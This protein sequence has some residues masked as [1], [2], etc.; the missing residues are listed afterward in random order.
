MMTSWSSIYLFGQDWL[1]RHFPESTL[2]IPQYL[3]NSILVML[4]LSGAALTQAVVNV[5]IWR[6]VFSKSMRG[7]VPKLLVDLCRIFIYLCAITG[8]AGTVFRYSLTGFWTTSSVFGLILGFALRNM[9]LDLFSGLAVNIERPYQVGDWVEVQQ[10]S[11]DLNLIGEVIEINWRSTRIRTESNSIVIIPNSILTT[12]VVTNHWGGGYPTRYEVRFCLD[13]SVSADRA[14]R[15][16]LAGVKSVY[17]LIGFVDDH[18]PSIMTGDTNEKGVNYIVRYWI[19]PWVHMTPAEAKNLVSNSVLQHLTKAGLTLAYPKQDLYYAEM[20]I[21]HLDT[22]SMSDRKKI[23][24]NIVLFMELEDQELT[25][26]S[27]RMKRVYFPQGDTV[28]ETGADADSMFILVEGFLQVFS[29][30]ENSQGKMRLGQIIPGEFFGEMSMLTGEPRS[31]SIKAATDVV[32][33]EITKEDVRWLFE[34][35][36]D[37]VE[38]IS[39]TVARRKLKNEAAK[40]LTPLIDLE[41]ETKSFAFQLVQRIQAFF[42]YKNSKKAYSVASLN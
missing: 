27:Q 3:T 10:K 13:F 31:A 39:K 28:I 37:F 12:Y 5:F 21:R 29:S 4:W 20:P 41:K 2:P 34:E 26:L 36:P 24:S 22:Y 14:H 1:L 35:R 32:C 8:I 25:Q 33:Y 11:K 17:H 16:L 9:I 38:L 18:E 23:L 40:T 15:V 30:L 7:E 42:N 6:G 19:K